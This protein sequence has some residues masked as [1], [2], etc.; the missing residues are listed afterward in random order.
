MKTLH[1]T[2]SSG[3]DVTNAIEEE[4]LRDDEGLHQHYG[5]GSN[6]RQEADNVANADDVQNDIAWSGQGA[7]EEGHDDLALISVD[8]VRVSGSQKGY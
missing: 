4:E 2:E 8:L 1:T 3:D 7:L 6:Y 5:A